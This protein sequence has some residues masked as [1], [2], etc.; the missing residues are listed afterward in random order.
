MS[1]AKKRALRTVLQ[2]IASG[3]LTGVVNTIAGGLSPA[4]LAEVLAGWQVVVTFAHNWLEDNTKFPTTLKAAP[5]A[6]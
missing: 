2:L 5:P 6:P 4:V 1:E 3:A